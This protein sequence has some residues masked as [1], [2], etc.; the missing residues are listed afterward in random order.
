[1][2]LVNAFRTQCFCLFPEIQTPT[3]PPSATRIVGGKKVLQKPVKT[4][5]SKVS[6]E[7][8]NIGFLYKNPQLVKGKS[9]FTLSVE[10]CCQ[11]SKNP[12]LFINFLQPMAMAQSLAHMLTKPYLCSYSGYYHLVFANLLPLTVH[13]CLNQ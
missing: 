10:N 2:F 12:S 11:L 4:V 7:T 9:V 6:P 1:M 8:T 13:V 5:E 3:L